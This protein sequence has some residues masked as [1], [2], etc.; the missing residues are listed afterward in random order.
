MLRIVLCTNL[1]VYS[2]GQIIDPRDVLGRMDMGEL[3]R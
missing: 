2:I 1:L 3:R